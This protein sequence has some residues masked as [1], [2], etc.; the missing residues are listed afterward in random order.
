MNFNAFIDQQQM[1]LAGHA[2]VEAAKLAGLKEIPTVSVESLT[3][4]QK[5]L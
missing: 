4:I 3:D 2:R 1:I 5:G